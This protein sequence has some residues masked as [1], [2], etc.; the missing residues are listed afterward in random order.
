MALI[1][2]AGSIGCSGAA[3]LGEANIEITGNADHTMSVAESTNL[4]IRVTSDG[5]STGIRKIICP[6]VEGTAYLVDNQTSEGFAITVIAASG[7]GATVAS[8]SS[9]L[10]FFDSTNY[11]D[12]SAITPV[13]TGT[14]LV[15]IT[16]GV[17]DG[18]AYALVTADLPHGAAAQL[19]VTNTGATAA[20]WVT[21][22][23]DGSMTAAGVFTCAKVNGVSYPSV[24]LTTGNAPYASSAS[25]VTY[26]PLNLAGGSGWVTGFLPTANIAV[27]TAAQFLIT[28]AGATAAGWVSCSGDS[29]MTAAG[30][31][32]NAKVNGVSYPSGALTTGNAPY[33]SGASAVTYGALNLAGGAGWIAGT[34]PTGN[35]GTGL[36][37]VGSV[38][39]YL[40]S[41]GA[42][43]AMSALLSADIPWASP[44]AI[45]ST[46]PSSGA[47]TTLV[48]ALLE[49]D[50][51]A[52]VPLSY[53]II[54][55]PLTGTTYTLSATEAAAR[56]LRFSGTPGGTC[57]ITMPS[58]M[59]AGTSPT[60]DV[61]NG[62]NQSITFA[63]GSVVLVAGA[64]GNL[65]YDGTNWVADPF[66]FG[67]DLAFHTSQSQTV[68]AINGATVPVAGAL[69]TGNAPYVSA[70]SALTYSALNLAGG[71]GWVAGT[72]PIGNGGTGLTAVGSAGQVLRSTGSAWA[73]AAIGVGD[74]P[75]GSAAQV[76]VTNAGATAAAWVSFSGDSSVTAAGV[77]TNAKVNGV[78]YP[79]GALTTGNA[80]YASAG[81]AVTYGALN[82]AGGAGWISGT[83]PTGNGGTGLT[84]V[85]SAAQYIRSTGSVFAMSALLSA[86]IPWASPGTL[87]STTP[88][89]GAFTTVIAGTLEGDPVAGVPLGQPV[90][91]RALTG[92]TYT[93]SATEAAA[94]FL[95]FSGTPGGTCTITMPTS[96]VSGTSPGY[97]VYNGTNQA[98]AFSPGTLV[99]AAGLKLSIYYDG[100]NWVPSSGAGYTL[101]TTDFTTAYEA[102]KLATSTGTEYAALGEVT[103]GGAG[104]WTTILDLLLPTT[105]MDLWSVKVRGWRASA[106]GDYY[107]ATL[108]SFI[109]KQ[110]SSVVTANPATPATTE[111]LSSGG[112]SSAGVQLNLSGAHVQIQVK[113]DGANAYRFEASAQ[114]ERST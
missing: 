72:L 65:Y 31:M 25:A 96:M 88:S 62:T 54:N 50:P 80:P 3:I 105:G 44:G 114:I 42:V 78:S 16:G 2:I 107:Y 20:G 98:I 17:E 76:L 26:G 23:G 27:G 52:G 111:S 104:A 91:N 1:T 86:D 94:R 8:L 24:A 74:L 81:S 83:L 77:M 39:Q 103:T 29:T 51:V 4:Y 34:L 6:A 49:G 95:R 18:A 79:S 12:L 109:V 15:H 14:G 59:A 21:C 55:R 110:V 38:G 22:S 47:F 64:K 9:A 37:A 40:R 41:T 35:G 43:F 108:Q 67:G 112:G 28:N 70:V 7:T 90:I 30:V 56:F 13:P 82:L 36:T 73:S 100:T 63:P 71:A 66:L 57:T 99:L 32:T 75:F 33:A 84:S 106:N 5:T 101:A 92:T 102:L 113:D 93:L 10:C 60:Y 48:A 68:V 97:D 85:G 45:G 69:V 19:L 61:Y 46:T 89:S 58:S 53:A 87:G 11:R